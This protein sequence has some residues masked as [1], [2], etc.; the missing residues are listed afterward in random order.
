MFFNTC[1]YDTF[2][3]EDL[4]CFYFTLDIYN[5]LR[6]LHIIKQFYVSNLFNNSNVHKVVAGKKEN[7]YNPHNRRFTIK[8]L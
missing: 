1:N 8:D 6:V 3:L 5:T 2:V 4:F 7:L